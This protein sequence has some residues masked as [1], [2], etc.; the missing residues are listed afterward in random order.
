VTGHG[1]KQLEPE[2][3]KDPRKYMKS[4]RQKK[5][6]PVDPGDQLPTYISIGIIKNEDNGGQAHQSGEQCGLQSLIH[7][8]EGRS[9]L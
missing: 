1:C 5:E 8:L 4:D 6:P 9:I 7:Q 2:R 3:V